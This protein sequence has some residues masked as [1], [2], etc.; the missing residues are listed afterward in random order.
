M[1]NDKKVFVMTTGIDHHDWAEDLVFCIAC[2]NGVGEDIGGLG[3]FE[4]YR[5]RDCGAIFKQEEPV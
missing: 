4:Y 1:N 5:C 2:E 3:H